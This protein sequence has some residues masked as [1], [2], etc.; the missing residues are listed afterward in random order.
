MSE[1]K[2]TKQNKTIEVDLKTAIQIYSSLKESNRGTG[3]NSRQ[4]KLFLKFMKI[5]EEN[6]VVFVEEPL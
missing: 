4:E 6:G 1:E 3:L 5:L 2:T